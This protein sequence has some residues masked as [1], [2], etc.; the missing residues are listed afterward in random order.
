VA[1][2][3]CWQGCGRPGDVRTEPGRTRQL[4]V[5]LGSIAVLLAGV[6]AAHGT[7]EGSDSGPRAASGPLPSSI[8]GSDAPSSE[9]PVGLAG[10]PPADRAAVIAASNRQARLRTVKPGVPVA[11]DIS[12]G[13]PAHPNGVHAKITS[14]P[15]NADDTL[16]VPS[17]PETVSWAKQ[18]AAPGATHGTVILT[19]HINFVINGQLVVGALS[20]LAWYSQHAIGKQFKLRLADGRRFTYRIVAGREYTKDQLADDPKLRAALYDQSKVYGPPNHPSGRLLL[21]SCGGAF[22][23]YTGEYED[24]VFLYALPVW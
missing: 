11:L 10:L 22:D 24:N 4:L 23:P 5:V 12:I 16:F 2:L 14:H 20:D 3:A 7:R 17:D 15:L 13:S 19:S 9:A 21:V 18:D 8:L 6:Y 1:P